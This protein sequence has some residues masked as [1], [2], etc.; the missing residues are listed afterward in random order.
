MIMRGWTITP[1]IHLNLYSSRATTTKVP[2]LRSP[3]LGRVKSEGLKALTFTN[4]IVSNRPQKSSREESGIT[5]ENGLC[6]VLRMQ[7]RSGVDK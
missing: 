4:S 2:F 7:V 3:A 1:F 5:G 6:V